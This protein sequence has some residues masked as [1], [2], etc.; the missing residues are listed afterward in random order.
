MHVDDGAAARDVRG[1]DGHRVEEPALEVTVD[2]RERD[3]RL[4][5]ALERLGVD[6]A[7]LTRRN[8]RG[9]ARAA[10]PAR[11]HRQDSAEVGLDEL[12][13]AKARPDVDEARR[14]SARLVGERRERAGVQRADRRAAQDVERDVTTEVL[15]DLLDDVLDDAHLVGTAR[16]AASEHQRDPGCLGRSRHASRLLDS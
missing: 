5:E 10:E 9:V 6:D 16:S 3:L 11:A 14:A 2:G 1:R 8:A 4:D 7:A 15:R 13:D 12:L